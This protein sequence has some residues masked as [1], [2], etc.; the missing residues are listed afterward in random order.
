M[1][2]TFKENV[3]DIRNSKVADVVNELKSFSCTVDVT[4]P[5]ADSADVEHEYGYPLEPEMKG[6]YDA[7]IVAV[8]HA[9]YANKDEAWFKGMLKPK[10]VLVD[11]KGSFRK[12]IKNLRYWSL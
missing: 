12:K 3:T 1:G 4:D 6:P 2:A 5:H 10:G 11:L 8:N 9:E 7:I